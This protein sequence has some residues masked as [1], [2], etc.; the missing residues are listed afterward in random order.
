M[1]DLDPDLVKQAEALGI[2]QIGGVIGAPDPNALL[3]DAV[4]TAAEI[5]ND[6]EFQKLADDLAPQKLTTCQLGNDA[7]SDHN[8]EQ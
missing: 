4:T 8:K 5:Y 6:P 7:K 3:T 2:R 1:H